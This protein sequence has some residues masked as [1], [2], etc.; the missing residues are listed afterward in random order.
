MDSP[1]IPILSSIERTYVDGGRETGTREVSD[2]PDSLD[3]FYELTAWRPWG[4]FS[5]E[6]LNLAIRDYGDAP[7][8]AALRAAHKTN[9]DRRGL[10]KQVLATL[11][12]NAEH[13]RRSTPERS[14]KA[15][16]QVDKQAYDAIRA[17]IARGE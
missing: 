13:A 10:L 7:V 11:A 1:S 4:Q 3:V 5:G 9:P 2:A 12:R 17:E 16:R 14:P 6:Q 15:G 8:T